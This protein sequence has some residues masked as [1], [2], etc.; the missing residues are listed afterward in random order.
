MAVGDDNTLPAFWPRV[1]NKYRCI[2]CVA[3]GANLL[4]NWQLSM[5]PQPEFS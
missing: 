5:L 2:L 1:N 4:Q 3:Y